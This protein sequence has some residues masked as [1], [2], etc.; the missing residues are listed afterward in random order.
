MLFSDFVIK[1]IIVASFERIA[2]FFHSLG[3]NGWLE[4][5]K[6]DMLQCPEIGY[7]FRVGKKFFKEK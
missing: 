4:A 3:S 6:Q 7:E 5:W 1:L 2:C